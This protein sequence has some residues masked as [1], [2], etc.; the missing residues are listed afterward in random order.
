MDSR[1]RRR[2]SFRLNDAPGRHGLCL[3]VVCQ[4]DDDLWENPEQL[5]RDLSYDLVRV[6]LVARR[7]DIVSIHVERIP[8]VYPI[9]VLDYPSRLRRAIQGVSEIANLRLLGRTGTFWYNNMDHSIRQA[10]DLA[11]AMGAGQTARGWN[12]TLETSSAF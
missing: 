4:D 7:D 8:E 12:A 6:G 11:A 3:E 9:Y 10:M 2:P 1:V 5:H